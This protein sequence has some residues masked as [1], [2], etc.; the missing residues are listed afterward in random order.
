M[1][2]LFYAKNIEYLGYQLTSN[3]LECQPKKVKAIQL[4]LPPTNVKQLK[5]FIGMIMFYQD[6]FEKQSH[7]MAPLIDLAAECGK[8]KGSKPKSPWK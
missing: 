3:G 5:W 1:Q 7:L 6:V 2:E 8:Q 4:V